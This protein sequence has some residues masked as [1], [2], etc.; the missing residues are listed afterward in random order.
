MSKYSLVGIDGNA[1]AIMGYVTKC[2]KAEGMDQEDIDNYRA[3]AM[4]SNYDHLFCVSCEM[5]DFLNDEYSDNYDDME[6]F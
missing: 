3:N 6:D 2:M 5:I 4:S 1:Y